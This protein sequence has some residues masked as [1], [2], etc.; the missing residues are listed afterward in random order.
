MSNYPS[1]FTPAGQPYEPVASPVFLGIE[2]LLLG[3]ALLLIALAAGLAYWLGRRRASDEPDA[4]D[5]IWR[6]IDN[7]CGAAMKVNSDAL[8]GRAKALRKE[9]TDRLGPVLTLADGINKPLK[10][11][12]AA[13][14]GKTKEP[15]HGDHAHAPPH[16][17]PHPPAHAPAHASGTPVTVVNNG[18][19]VIRTDGGETPPHTDGHPP[20]PTQPTH[21]P[22]PPK[23][24]DMS[25]EEQADA[26]R[27]AVARF[28]DHWCQKTPRIN[29]LRAAHRALSRT[30]PVGHGSGHVGKPR[31]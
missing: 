15:A 27:R 4:A 11:L 2:P 1:D 22:A 29:E 19:V 24:R 6:A 30:A 18:H 12:D 8:P 14:K 25:V 13:L 20:A 16:A 7:A 9:I 31:H 17:N 21:P 28:N 5:A 10:E 23:D 26:L 3:A